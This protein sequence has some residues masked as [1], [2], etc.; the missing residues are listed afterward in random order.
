[1]EWYST[2]LEVVADLTRVIGR[3]RLLVLEGFTPVNDHGL[4]P[5]NAP[6]DH[7]LPP[8]IETRRDSLTRTF[9]RELLLHQD[10]R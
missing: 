4:P 10:R 5:R 9:M 8:V 3:S 6:C 2:Y 1:M 7:G